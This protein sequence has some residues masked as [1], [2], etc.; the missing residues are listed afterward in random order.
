MVS[1]IIG[2]RAFPI[3]WTL[4][5]KKGNSSL[6]EQTNVLKPVL[7]LL[8]DYNLIVLGDREFHSAKLAEYS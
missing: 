5:D 8:K 1:V 6:E 2:K 3:Y 7:E 4:L